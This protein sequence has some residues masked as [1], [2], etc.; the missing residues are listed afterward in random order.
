MPI[1]HR[2]DQIKKERLKQAKTG[3]HSGD[4]SAIKHDSI[5]SKMSSDCKNCDYQGTVKK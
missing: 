5:A 3:G 1:G 2:L 4:A